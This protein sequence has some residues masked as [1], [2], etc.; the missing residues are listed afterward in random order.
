MS[1]FVR[2]S[3]VALLL[4]PGSV[5]ADSPPADTGKEDKATSAPAPDQGSNPEP[6]RKKSSDDPGCGS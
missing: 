4:L 3:L 6:D 2:L 5:W 1:R